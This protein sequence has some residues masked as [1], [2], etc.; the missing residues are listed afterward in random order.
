MTQGL[1]KIVLRGPSST[2]AAGPVNEGVSLDSNAI[3]TMVVYVDSSICLTSVTTDSPGASP[4][5]DQVGPEQISI[6][7]HT[8]PYTIRT[9]G[10]RIVLGILSP[11]SCIAYVGLK[12]R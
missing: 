11:S 12:T 4:I 2:S 1:K 5:T 7:R 10:Q 6:G 3:R 8:C 9:C